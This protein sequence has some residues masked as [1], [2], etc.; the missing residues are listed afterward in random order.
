VTNSG[1]FCEAVQKNSVIKIRVIAPALVRL[2]ETAGIGGI[3][4]K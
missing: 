1:A 2:H 3:E 4:L